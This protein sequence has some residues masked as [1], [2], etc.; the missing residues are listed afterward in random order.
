[1]SEESN[2][3]TEVVDAPETND[4]TDKSSDQIFEESFDSI[5]LNDPSTFSGKEDKA[6]ESNKDPE[7]EEVEVED[8]PKAEEKTETEDEEV[9]TETEDKTE[10]KEQEEEDAEQALEERAKEADKLK[11]NESKFEE[12]KESKAPAIKFPTVEDAIKSMPEEKA[13]KAKELVE[14]FPEMVDLFEAMFS[15]QEQEEDKQPELTPEQKQQKIEDARFW[16]DLI[17][18]RPDAEELLNSNEFDDWYSKQNS[19]IKDLGEHGTADDV[20]M[21]IKAYEAAKNRSEA[22]K[23]EKKKPVAKK[24]TLLK[25]SVTSSSKSKKVAKTDE[26][27]FEEGWNLKVK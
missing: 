11:R 5:D 22:L 12:P 16:T 21:I 4:A 6:E 7:E 10:E 17:G 18:K 20:V 13:K 25:T 1:M 8:D 27:E 23:E 14:E 3:T 19:K 2:D 26:E 9:D 15:P 24:K